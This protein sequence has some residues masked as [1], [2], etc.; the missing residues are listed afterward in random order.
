MDMKVSEIHG[1][2]SV[3]ES[4]DKPVAVSEVE[5]VGAYRTVARIYPDKKPFRFSIP[6]GGGLPP[7]PDDIFDA[8]EPPPPDE[9]IGGAALRTMYGD[10]FIKQFRHGCISMEL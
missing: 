3:E 5:L 10:G 2:S 9:G 6:P 1:V 8:V 4:V 7:P